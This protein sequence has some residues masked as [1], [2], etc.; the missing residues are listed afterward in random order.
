METG[1][2]ESRHLEELHPLAVVIGE[3][4][5]QSLGQLARVHMVSE[6]LQRGQY[7]HLQMKGESGGIEDSPQR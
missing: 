6:G 7:L 3:G 1:G 4:A 2:Y 5:L